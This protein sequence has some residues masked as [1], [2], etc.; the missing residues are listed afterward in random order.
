MCRLRRICRNCRICRISRICIIC[1]IC[2]ICRKCRIQ[3]QSGF[4]TSL[5][6]STRSFMRR[7]SIIRRQMVNH[8]SYLSQAPQAVLCKI[9][10]SGV[11]F[12]RLSEKMHI[13]DFFK[14]IFSVFGAFSRF[15]GCKFGFR[16]TCQCK[17]NDKYEV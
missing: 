3:R 5:Y 17:R 1:R 11:Y 2:K 12:S 6:F 10:L 4:D 14:D 7:T 16:K 15:F 9:F 13:F 8:T